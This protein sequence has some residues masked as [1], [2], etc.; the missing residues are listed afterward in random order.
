[1]KDFW[2]EINRMLDRFLT[3][4]VKTIL[5][6]NVVVTLLLIIFLIIF[7]RLTN[8]AVFLLAQAPEYSIKRGFLWQFLTYMF[9]HVEPFHMIVNMLVLW[10]F[11]PPLER[12]WG[13]RRF[14]KFYLIVGI[15]AGILHAIVALTTGREASNY[16]IGA[17]G[18]IYG[19][20]LA[21]AAYYP[22]QTVYLWMVFPIKVK[23]LVIVLG[24]FTF[25]ATAGGSGAGN[26]SNL[27]HLTG[28][29]VAYGYLA[30]YHG[31]WDIKRWRWMH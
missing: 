31:T 9:I 5:I 22:N 20:L 4:A 3:P 2:E 1:M 30:H 14:W 28:L 7:P 27:T 13:T 11:G 10:F 21:F 29:I 24:L 19:V 15:G 26:V 16:I 23:Y 8:T 12:D 6:I 25:L 17:S 18:A